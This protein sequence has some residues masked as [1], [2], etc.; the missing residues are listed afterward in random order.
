M[1]LLALLVVLV[2]AIGGTPVQGGKPIVA[3]PANTIFVYTAGDR[4]PIWHSRVMPGTEVVRGQDGTYSWLS[5]DQ[6][7]HSFLATAGFSVLICED[8]DYNSN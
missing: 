2:L 8:R 3:I 6:R 7:P 1:K 4:E 5:E